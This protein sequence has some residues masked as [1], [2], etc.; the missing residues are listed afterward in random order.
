MRLVRRAARSSKL[1]FL[2]LSAT[3]FTLNLGLTV[4][5]SEGL[6][7]PSEA[8]FPLAMAVTFAVNFLALRY[9]VYGGVGALGVCGQ[10]GAF[11]ASSLAFRLSEYAAF[12]GLHTLIGVPTAVAVLLVLTASTVAKFHAYKGAVFGP[13][14]GRRG[15]AGGLAVGPAVPLASPAAPDA[16]AH[17]GPRAGPS[18]SHRRGPVS[19]RGEGRDG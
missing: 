11:L 10:L 1:R 4:V 9:W 5:L 6:G 15:R 16:G 2:F 18:G 12:L 14:A 17:Q 19:P 13:D 3:S 8:T 7:L